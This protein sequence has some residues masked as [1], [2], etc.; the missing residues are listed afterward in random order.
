MGT[1]FTVKSALGLLTTTYLSGLEHHKALA[2]FGG[3]GV[4]GSIIGNF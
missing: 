3:T 2:I 1:G 4:I